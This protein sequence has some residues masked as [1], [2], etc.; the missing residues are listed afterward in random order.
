MAKR[1]SECEPYELNL[2][3]GAQRYVEGNSIQILFDNLYGRF[4]LRK[5]DTVILK[6]AVYDAARIRLEEMAGNDVDDDCTAPYGE[7]YLTEMEDEQCYMELKANLL[8][9]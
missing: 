2:S 6:N 3:E 5:E 7:D 8:E 4:T 9:Q 1:F